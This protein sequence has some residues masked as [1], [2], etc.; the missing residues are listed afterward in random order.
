MPL[1]N[2]SPAC[3]PQASDPPYSH[4]PVNNLISFAKIS[5]TDVEQAICE[6]SS[7]AAGPDGLEIKF[8]KTDKSH[9]VISTI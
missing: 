7:V 8:L 9:S 1:V 3:S 4:A 6:L 5:P 2:T